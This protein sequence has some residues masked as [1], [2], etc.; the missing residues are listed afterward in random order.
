MG[1]KRTR[2]NNKS[3]RLRLSVFKS[4]KHIYAQI[5][6]D[7]QGKTLCQASSLGNSTGGNVADAK[8]VGDKIAKIALKNK[9]DTIVFDRGK[10]PYKGRIKALASA[11]R[12][13]GLKF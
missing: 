12:E 7:Q 1:Y 6:D 4:S 11:A 2:I 5:I 10:V 8:V 13:Q 9:I 3:K